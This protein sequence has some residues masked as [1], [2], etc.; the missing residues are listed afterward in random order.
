MSQTTKTQA[1]GCYNLA[2]GYENPNRNLDDDSD[3]EHGRSNDDKDRDTPTFS[4]ISF[5]FESSNSTNGKIKK[6]Q[7]PK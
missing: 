4:D 5:I 1:I 2:V 6:H 3:L 7:K